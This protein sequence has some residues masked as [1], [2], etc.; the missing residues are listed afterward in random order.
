V[1]SDRPW[2]AHLDRRTAPRPRQ[3]P[4]GNAQRRDHH[5]P[6]AAGSFAEPPRSGRWPAAMAVL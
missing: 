3:P 6:G 2:A 5:A 1:V 4:P